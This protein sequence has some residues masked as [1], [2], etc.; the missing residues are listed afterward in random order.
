MI[1]T[2]HD[3]LSCAL[4]ISALLALTAGPTLADA[5]DED[6][7]GEVEI[8][9]DD[10]AEAAGEADDEAAPERM[11]ALSDVR[12][13]PNEMPATAFFGPVW[14]AAG[15]ERAPVGL[16]RMADLLLLRP[17]TVGLGVIG[18]GMYALAVGP[19][20]IAAP[21][22]HHDMVDDLLLSPWRFLRDR[23]LG[24]AMPET[25]EDEAPADATSTSD[26]DPEEVH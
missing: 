11:R 26:V 25:G 17:L 14:G 22:T 3:L 2:R 21:E 15:I 6:M 16:N 4:L 9:M 20:M 5:I 12:W 1:R 23:P 24:E 8:P 7:A 18:A 10:S 19:A 13:E